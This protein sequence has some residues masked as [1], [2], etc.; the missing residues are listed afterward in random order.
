MIIN[1]ININVNNNNNAR[2]KLIRAVIIINKGKTPGKVLVQ[3]IQSTN[4][5]FLPLL[6]N[7]ITVRVVHTI[8]VIA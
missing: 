1:M 5:G 4:S 6:I 7:I 8:Y 2:A 3:S